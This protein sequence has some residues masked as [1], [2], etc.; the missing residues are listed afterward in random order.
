MP[1]TSNGDGGGGAG[2]DAAETE[3]G[4]EPDA[5]AEAEEAASECSYSTVS[6]HTR[7]STICSGLS[8]DARAAADFAGLAPL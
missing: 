8:A 6:S 3:A 5:E 7:R 1:S 4:A 2:K